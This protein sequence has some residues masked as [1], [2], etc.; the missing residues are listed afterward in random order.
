MWC[1]GNRTN[2]M[3]YIIIS[4]NRQVT[5]IKKGQYASWLQGRMTQASSGAMWW[6]FMTNPAGWFVEAQVKTLRQAERIC[7][8]LNKAIYE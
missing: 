8:S 4:S 3:N 2:N 5:A 6:V 7:S 1:I